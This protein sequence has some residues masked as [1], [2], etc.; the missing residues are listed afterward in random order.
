MIINGTPYDEISNIIDN[1]L[2]DCCDD[3]ECIR[4]RLCRLDPEVRES[5]LTSDLLNAWQ[6]FYYYFEEDPGKDILEFLLFSPASSLAD[7]IFLGEY[8]N[9]NIRFSVHNSVPE[10]LL[11]DDIQ[12]LA[13]YSGPDAFK[14]SIK[15]INEGN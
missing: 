3:A 11:S 8:N 13:R 15:F 10:I 14:E 1:I 2:S 6:V 9:C 4:I 7:G 12:E 5:I